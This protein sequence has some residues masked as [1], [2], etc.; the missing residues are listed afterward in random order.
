MYLFPVLSSSQW[1]YQQGSD[2]SPLSSTMMPF[3]LNT[4]VSPESPALA[5]MTPDQV[6]YAPTVTED[7]PYGCQVCEKAFEKSSYLHK[8]EQVSEDIVLPSLYQI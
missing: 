3:S 4:P 7:H 1:P 6:P 5:S 8:H 2:S